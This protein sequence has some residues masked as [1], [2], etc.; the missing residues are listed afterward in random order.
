ME[1]LG[2][3]IVVGRGISVRFCDLDPKDSL[4]S[5]DSLKLLKDRC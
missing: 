2:I 1:D 4:D 5:F 3:C